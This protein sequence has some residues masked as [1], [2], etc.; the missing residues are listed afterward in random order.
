MI[1]HLHIE[2][3]ISYDFAAEILERAPRKLEEAI[4]AGNIT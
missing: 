4:H 3:E 1:L 2:N